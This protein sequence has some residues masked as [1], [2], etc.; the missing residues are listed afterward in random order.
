MS[1]LGLSALVAL[2][3]SATSQP[4][5]YADLARMSPDST[6][7]RLESTGYFRAGRGAAVYVA[8]ALADEALLARHPR[9]VFRTG[10]GRIFRLSPEG[11]SLSAEQGGALGDG[12][13]D[14]R[15]AIQAAIDYAEKAGAGEV[16]FERTHYRLHCP[17]RTSPADDARAEDGH[18]LVV[19]GSLALR[20]CAR[21]PSV[22]DFRGP[23]GADPETGW[24]VV[25]ASA[26]DATPVVWR[27]GGLLVL[28]ELSDPAP[29][30]R[31][32]ARLELERLVLR[33]NRQRTGN[34][35]FPADPVTGDGWDITDKAFW[36]QDCLAG[37][38]VCR[39][40]D[41]IGWKGEIFYL[42]GA[43][44]G[45]ERVELARCRFLT[46]NAVA[47]NPATDCVTLA[48]D[49]EFG[50]ASQAQEDTGKSRAV[51]RNCLWRDCTRTGFGSG[52]THGF[53]H[54]VTY[55]TR[56]ET[57]PVPA[58]ELLDC[59]FHDCG[60]LAIASWVRGRIVTVDTQVEI[61]GVEAMALRDVDLAIDAW[62]DRRAS[63][64][65]LVFYGPATLTEPVPNAPAGTYRQPPT[66]VRIRLRHYRSA[67]A[68]AQGREWQSMHW[69]GYIARD[70]RIEV[71]GDHA[72]ARTPHG[73]DNPLSM[74][75][76]RFDR[77]QATTAYTP[78]GSYAVADLTASG[79]LPPPGPF[80]ALSVT[81]AITVAVTL[82][83]H[84]AG[85]AAHGYAD[86]QVVRFVKMY[87]AGAITFTKG[88]APSMALMATRTLDLADDWIEFT[89]NR[90]RSRWE[91]SGFFS[92]V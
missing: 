30:P 4:A 12:A 6:V 28:G 11:G 52:P 44:N 37:T 88:A 19:R 74:P 38:I 73:G 60:T 24:Q 91:E 70:C 68:A 65:A 32:I 80:A 72:S 79:S 71:E 50:D 63:F 9:F 57:A 35:T 21:E 58:T 55:P 81:S 14:D 75:L 62:I 49:C 89:Y 1:A 59:R 25:R 53:L 41:M 36:L 67:L 90:T 40:V 7:L 31:R 8:D 56:D 15:P 20:G 42:G 33:G 82:P 10:N 85:G 77:G 29:A 92:A 47:M 69:S 86:G 23:G 16:R 87:D 13:S 34:A 2:Q 39:D 61:N 48:E 17:P 76:V 46:T 43:D 3:R 84:P 27:G 66:Q 78:Q 18:P 64:E 54:T 26:A 45:V 51:Y 22:L 83:A 5:L